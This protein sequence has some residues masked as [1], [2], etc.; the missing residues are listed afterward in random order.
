MDL[1][2]TISPQEVA[3]IPQALLHILRD[4]IC[5]DRAHHWSDLKREE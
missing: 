2:L 3:G 5:R 1:W 4:R